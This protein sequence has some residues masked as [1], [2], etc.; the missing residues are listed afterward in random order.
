M[1]FYIS[2]TLKHSSDITQNWRKWDF[3]KD[4][5]N[6]KFPHLHVHKV[7]PWKIGTALV[8][9]TYIVVNLVCIK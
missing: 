5:I 7:K 9:F 8:I 2:V 6:A 1:A 4:S 3:S